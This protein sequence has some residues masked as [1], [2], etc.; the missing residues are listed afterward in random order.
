MHALDAPCGRSRAHAA[1]RCG[2]DPFHAGGYGFTL[3]GDHNVRPRRRAQ[4]FAAAL[5][6]NLSSQDLNPYSRDATMG[7]GIGKVFTNGS[8]PAD[9]VGTC[10]HA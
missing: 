5:I 8:T 1:R 2:N 7:G 10:V 4:G 3:Q 6:R 9:S